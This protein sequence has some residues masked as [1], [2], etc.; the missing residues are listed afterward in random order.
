V[1]YSFFYQEG[2][3]GGGHLPARPRP[4]SST[5]RSQGQAMA[6]MALVIGILFA[7]VLGGLDLLQ[8]V[9]TH[10]QVNQA[11]RAGAHQA[12]LIG[13]PDGQN[14]S[15]G[16]GGPAPSGTVAELVRVYL[17]GGI[18]TS[19]SNATI[20]VSCARTPCR[21]YD[22]ITVRVVYKGSVWAPLPLL[23][24]EFS[25]ERTATRASEKDGQ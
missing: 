16:A 22:P 13:G 14:G 19:A 25:V 21:R 24:R 15:W 8:M 2:A 9:L 10:Y 23:P 11:V 3:D 5:R 6:E 1:L 17:D 18:V 20:N 7:V 4:S 12:A